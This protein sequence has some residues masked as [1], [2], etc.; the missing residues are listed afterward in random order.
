VINKIEK[1]GLL[2]LDCEGAEYEIL[3]TLEEGIYAKIQRIIL[4]FH[5][6]CPKKLEKLRRKLESE[7]FFVK[8]VVSAYSRTEGMLYCWKKGVVGE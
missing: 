7:G 3:D 2:K 8:T 4:E 6:G 1:C 5:Q